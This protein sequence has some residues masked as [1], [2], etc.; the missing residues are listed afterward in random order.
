MIKILFVCHGNICRSPMA[1]FVFNDLVNNSE[2]IDKVTTINPTTGK[3]S[4]VGAL[5]QGILNTNIVHIAGQLEGIE[6]P[7]DKTAILFECRDVSMPELFG[8]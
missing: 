7:E 3:P 5:V 2:K 6:K 4:L 8:A 1:E